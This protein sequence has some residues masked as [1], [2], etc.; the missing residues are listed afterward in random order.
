MNE[1]LRGCGYNTL[2][3][4]LTPLQFGIPNSRLRYY[5]LAKRQPASFAS[6]DASER[7]CIWRHI[8][9]HGSPW[10]DTREDCNAAHLRAYLDPETSTDTGILYRIPGRV[11]LKWGRLFDIVQP[12]SR[13]SCCFTRGGLCLYSNLSITLMHRVQDTHSW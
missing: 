11:L 1:S 2:E 8:P 4:L 5:L 12:N 9:G 10:K 13:R 6:I 7:S 3:L